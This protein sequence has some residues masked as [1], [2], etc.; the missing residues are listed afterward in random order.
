M[1][2]ILSVSLALSQADEAY[3]SWS[4]L[5]VSQRTR[6]QVAG[7]DLYDCYVS[8]MDADHVTLD[9]STRKID[10]LDREARTYCAKELRRYRRVR[11]DRAARTAFRD[12]FDEYWSRL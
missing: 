9:S 2:L 6:A 7:D 5:P 12:I 10:R 11:G 3:G 4:D 8:L 1:I